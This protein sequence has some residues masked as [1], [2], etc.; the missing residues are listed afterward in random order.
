MKRWDLSAL[1]SGTEAVERSLDVCE[2]LSKD[3][4][5]RYKGKLGT[6]PAGEFNSALKEYERLREELGRIMSYAF[7]LFA[8]DTQKGD[9]YADYEL[10]CNFV[11]EMLLF[12]EIEFGNLKE[13][14]QK[15][16]MNAA[17]AYAYYLEQIVQN[18]KHTLTLPEERILLKLSPVGANAFARLFDEHLSSLKF[19]KKAL[20]EEEVLALLHHPKRAKRKK[21]AKLLTQ[22]LAPH[23]ELLAF[24]LN[25]VRKENA[26]IC[27]L[28]GY[29]SPEHSR[30]I[31]NQTTQKSVDSMMKCI[32]A[33]MG[34]VKEFYL[35]KRD[36]LG[37]ERL[38]DYD[39]YA[40]LEG[41]NREISFEEAHKIV[42]GAFNNFSP[43]FGEI[44]KRAFEEGWI[45]S[46]PRERKRGGAFSHGT[47]P[48]AH[49]Y[50][51]LNHT[52]G[53]RDLFTMAHELGHAI[54]QELSKDVGYLSADTP[55]TTA[56][57]ASVFAEM[58]LF[59]TL[60]GTLKKEE[61]IALMAGKLEDIF[62]TLFRQGVFTN[63]ERR[64]HDHEGELK[65]TEYNK[66]WL[67]EN[68]KM[69]GESVCLREE[70]ASWW[71]YIPHFVHTPFYCYAYSYGQLLVMAL[72]GLYKQG[73]PQFVERYTEFLSLGGSRSPKELVGLFGLDIEDESFWDIGIKEVDALLAEFEKAV[74][75]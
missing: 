44:A 58:L 49:P 33:N 3:F 25:N 20:G 34:I 27:K 31:E 50:V 57:T 36:L 51:L 35:L 72:F 69:F 30:H 52:N 6:I 21:A 13:S 19:G 12:F 23:Q 68:R 9:I 43:R 24:I 42:L 56:E 28:K 18:K 54:H 61:K 46:H 60:K 64:I 38:Y 32:N 70:Y 15:T 41:E 62:A 39:R 1:F 14:R 29:D 67:T 73:Y 75:S 40:P 55:L 63:F 37:L 74:R 7:L 48:S 26:I 10:Y 47:V 71:S 5:K 59:D 4:K 66:I 65:S 2:R 17:P 11:S 22:G 8:E 45:D 16:L 53:R